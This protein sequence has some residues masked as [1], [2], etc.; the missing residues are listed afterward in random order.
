MPMAYCDRFRELENR[1]IQACQE[2]RAAG[3]AI[4]DSKTCQEAL[5]HLRVHAE[6]CS[7][8]VGAFW[9]LVPETR[10]KTLTMLSLVGGV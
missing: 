2:A 6:F 4:S 5:T 7:E 9:A 3:T 10:G 1:W 8:C